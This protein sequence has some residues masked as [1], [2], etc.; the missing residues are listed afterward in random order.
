MT[1]HG[2]FPYLFLFQIVELL[3][4]LFFYDAGMPLLSFGCL[5]LLFIATSIINSVHSQDPLTEEQAD[6]YMKQWELNEKKIRLLYEMRMTC[7]GSARDDELM[8]QYRALEGQEKELEARIEI[9][10]PISRNR[11]YLR[12]K[13]KA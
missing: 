2:F 11:S 3:S 9:H 13:R 8:R 5:G 1:L 4:A 12:W 10:T 7:T 6:I